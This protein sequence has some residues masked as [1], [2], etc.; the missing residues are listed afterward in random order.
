MD[1]RKIEESFVPTDDGK[2]AVSRG[3]MV[4]TA[5]PDA[6]NAG[7]EMLRLEGNAVDAACAAALALGVCEPQASG[8]GGQSTAILHL[9]GST[10]AVDGSSRAPSLAHLDHF[11]KGERTTG[12]RAATVP[13][14][15]AVLGHLNFHYGKLDW[16]TVLQPA[17]RI[18]EEGYR[19]TKLQSR[20]QER[21]KERF[22]NVASQSGAAY[23]L[24]HGTVPYRE[25]DLFVQNDLAHLLKRLAGKGPR[26]FYTGDVAAQIDE[27][28]RKNDGFLRAEDLALIPWPI[29][30]KPLKRRYRKVVIYTCPPP[31]AGR[32]LLLTLMMLNNLPSKFIK[33]RSPESCHFIA[34]TFR[35]AFLQRKQR[36]Y[37]PNYY[38]QVTEKEML[39]RRF[40]KSLS[41]SIRDVIDTDIP[42]VNPFEENGETTHLSVMDSEGNAA[43]ITQSIERVYGSK[44]AAKELGFLYNNYMVDFEIKEPSHPYYLRPNSIPWTTVAPIIAFYKKKPWIVAGSPGSERIYSTISQFLINMIDRGYAMSDAM[45][46]PRLHCST[47]GTIH[48]EAERFDPVIIKYLDEIG[49]TIEKREAYSFYLGAVHAVLKCKTSE[50][51]QAVAET[52]RDGTSAGVEL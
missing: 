14:T 26:A 4:S 20:L 51:F 52:R 22:L 46:D 41:E 19:I 21:E 18:A 48:V 11:V 42:L 17:I 7:V 31:A 39:S 12:Y 13:S 34:E 8:I 40:A 36:P 2:C 50:G 24:K 9:R 38:P 23:F 44:A 30:R 15:V 3:G 45:L 28:M 27:D 49:Y 29:E 5:F 33:S 10:I 47:N 16:S 37:D 6:T 1:I 32:T 43:G 25:G 35:K